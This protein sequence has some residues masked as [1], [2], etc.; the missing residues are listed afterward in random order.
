MLGENKKGVK[1][2]EH[3]I[4]NG[5]SFIY[6]QFRGSSET[7]YVELLEDETGELYFEFAKNKYY[8]VD[9]ALL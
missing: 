6:I 4:I 1:I 8:I 3:E 9:F 7:Y 2:L 5:K